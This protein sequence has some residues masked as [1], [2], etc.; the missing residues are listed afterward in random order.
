MRNASR[1]RQQKIILQRFRGSKRNRVHQGVKFPVALLQLGKDLVDLF[2]A[3]N[4]A[5][6]NSGIRQLPSEGFCFRPEPFV[7]VANSNLRSGRGKLL[8]DRP[9]DTALIGQ[10]EYDCRLAFEI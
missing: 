2:I 8:G 10:A 1:A 4:V 7:L 6:E 9:G 5:L 3:R